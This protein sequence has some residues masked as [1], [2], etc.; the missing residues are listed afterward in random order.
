MS[1]RSRIAFRPTPLTVQ[2]LAVFVGLAQLAFFVP[3]DCSEDRLGSS[4]NMTGPQ[5]LAVR[6]KELRLVDPSPRVAEHVG[7]WPSLLARVRRSNK[8]KQRG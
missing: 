5:N 3:A 6:K 2:P 4:D 7:R 8:P 1:A